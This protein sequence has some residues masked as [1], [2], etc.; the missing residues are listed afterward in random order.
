MD[1]EGNDENMQSAKQNESESEL[2]NRFRIPTHSPT[3]CGCR[4]SSEVKKDRRENAC[5]PVLAEACKR[6][7]SL[8][9]GL[10]LPLPAPVLAIAQLAQAEKTTEDKIQASLRAKL[11]PGD[12]EVATDEIAEAS[13]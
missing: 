9:A 2:S 5:G 3:E 4:R 11:G 6:P 10:L 8:G 13:P 1:V 7:M 12:S